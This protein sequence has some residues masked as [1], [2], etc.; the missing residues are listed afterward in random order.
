MS[1]SNALKRL[2]RIRDLEQEQHRLALESALSEMRVLEDA[3]AAAAE[4]ERSGRGEYTA[5]VRTGEFL[6]Q[7]SAIVETS[8]GGQH[9]TALNPAL[10]RA[11]AEAARRRHAFLLKRMEHRQAETLIE[12]AKA[13]DAYDEARVSQQTLDDWFLSRIIRIQNL[14][15]PE[16]NSKQSAENLERIATDTKRNAEESSNA[17]AA[18][19]FPLKN[20]QE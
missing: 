8:I 13:E 19:L 7:H 20:L 5:S 3:L 4:R 10:L 16:R 11:Q 2:L 15:S 12:E 18:A 1:V 14:P 17:P 9:I 6:G